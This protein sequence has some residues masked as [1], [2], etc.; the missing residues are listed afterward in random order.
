MSFSLNEPPFFLFVALPAL[1]EKLSRYDLLRL[2]VNI[3]ATVVDDQDDLTVC[4]MK[5]AATAGLRRCGGG[6]D[7]ILNVRPGAQATRERRRTTGNT[8]LHCSHM[9][10]MPACVALFIS[11]AQTDG[12]NHQKDSAIPLETESDATGC[13]H[14]T[15]PMKKKRDIDTNLKFVTGPRIVTHKAGEQGVHCARKSGMAALCLT[16]HGK[17]LAKL[18]RV[19]RAGW[20]RGGLNSVVMIVPSRYHQSRAIQVDIVS[21]LARFKW[22]EVSAFPGRL[23]TT[24]V[25]CKDMLPSIFGN[26]VVSSPPPPPVSVHA[27]TMPHYC[28]YWEPG[29]ATPSDPLAFVIEGSIVEFLHNERHWSHVR[30]A[31]YVMMR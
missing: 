30:M 18:N 22:L 14:L 12:G 6:R 11:I 26:E 31:P 15:R 21:L 9:C 7:L 5:R 4:G 16:K 27:K 2:D 24:I 23:L 29:S 19:I 1:Y 17:G 10:K 8:H 13:K 28:R 20:L 3:S 25:V